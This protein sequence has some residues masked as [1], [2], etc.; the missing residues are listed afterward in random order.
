MSDPGLDGRLGARIRALRAERNLS[1]DGLAQR[2]EVSRAM[3]SRIERGESSPTAQLLGKVCGGLGIALSRLFA[4]AETAA[5]PLLRRDAQPLWRDPGSGYLRR[6]VSPSGTG[7]A[8]DIAEIVFP[9]GATVAFDNRRLPGADQHVWVLDG[10]L[11]VDLDGEPVSLATGDCLLMRFDRPV[12]FRN[13]TA[14]PVRY[15]VILSHGASRP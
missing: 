11:E 14:Q 5:S 2:A 13:P 7:S 15:A 8:V 6:A 12:V 3:L 1:L 9:A 10:T 4:E